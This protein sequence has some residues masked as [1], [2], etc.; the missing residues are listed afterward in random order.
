MK[1]GTRGWASWV[2]FGGCFEGSCRGPALTQQSHCAEPDR[3]L[4]EPETREGALQSLQVPSP[5]PGPGEP[6][7]WAQ[8]IH[9]RGP[10]T[11]PPAGPERAPWR[12]GAGKRRGCEKHRRKKGKSCVRQTSTK[13][14]PDVAKSQIHARR[15]QEE[16]SV[17][18]PHPWAVTRPGLG[19][20]LQSTRMCA[21][22]SMHMCSHMC[23]RACTRVC[24]R[25]SMHVCTCVCMCVRTHV[26][27]PAVPCEVR[28]GV[29]GGK[30]APPGAG[31]LPI[32]PRLSEETDFVFSD[33]LSLTF[34]R[35]QQKCGTV[36]L[37]HTF[38]C[39]LRHTKASVHRGSLNR[40]C[41]FSF[42]SS[43]DI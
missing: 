34:V 5:A 43:Q 11:E 35:A 19:R 28:E 33:R 16:V 12:G 17:L 6:V 42:C 39:F 26:W 27:L 38:L 2:T 31:L 18:A 4:G 24:I 30:D 14:A 23:G 36:C 13:V 8:S 25:A 29:G 7:L 10:G 32:L 3:L 15:P 1:L 9:A 37:K 41:V 20:R 40:H 21:R 22:V